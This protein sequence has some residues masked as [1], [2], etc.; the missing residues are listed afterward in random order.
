[1]LWNI[2]FIDLLNIL[3]AKPTINPTAS[4]ITWH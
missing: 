2:E 1:M 4:T 3:W